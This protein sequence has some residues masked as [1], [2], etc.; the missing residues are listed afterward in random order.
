MFALIALAFFTMVLTGMPIAFALGLTGLLG[1]LMT[2]G[3]S[4]LMLVPQQIFSG[5][6][7]FVLMA[8]PC[9]SSP[10]N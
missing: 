6:N 4:L 8:I 9:S 10:G 2:M 3:T 1:L 5:M 7:S